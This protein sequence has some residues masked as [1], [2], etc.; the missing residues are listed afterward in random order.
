MIVVL[1][2]LATAGCCP[3]CGLRNW[4]EAKPGEGSAS[5]PRGKG[6]ETAPQG[7]RNSMIL[8][9]VYHTYFIAHKTQI[10]QNH[11]K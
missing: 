9:Y 8:I 5:V 10:L 4:L 2:V 11:G 6:S 7:K 3:T 1:A